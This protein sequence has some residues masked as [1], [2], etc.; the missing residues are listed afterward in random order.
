MKFSAGA[1]IRAIAGL[2]CA[3]LMAAA[4]VSSGTDLADG[5]QPGADENIVLGTDDLPVAVDENGDPIPASIGDP[6]E[7]E[8]EAS[9]QDLVEQDKRDLVAPPADSAKA[10]PDDV[11]A[12]GPRSDPDSL[13]V[14]FEPGTTDEA[15]TS[16]LAGAGVEGERIGDSDAVLV[17]TAGVDKAEVT[18]ALEA[19]GAVAHVEPNLIR[20]A[21]KVPNDPQTTTQRHY[22]DGLGIQPAWDVANTGSNVV[23]AV[24]DTGVD[25]DH[26]DLAPNLVP[27]Y[28]AVNP[29]ASPQ[30]DNGHGTQVA[31]IIGAATNNGVGIAG[32]AWNA[33]IMPVKVLNAQGYGTDSDIVEGIRWA[34][35]HGADVINMSLGGPGMSMAIDEAVEFA[36]GIVGG[37]IV[38]PNDSVLVAA[39]GN[40]ASWA[41][42]YP[43]AAPG[44][45]AVSATDH[46]NDYFWRSNHGAWIDIAAPGI[47]IT[48]TALAPGTTPAIRTGTGTSFSSPIVAG[49]AA[50]VRE[51]HPGWR[52]DRVHWEVLRTATDR[53]PA[54]HDDAYGFG[55]VNAAAALGVAGAGTVSQPSLTGDAGNLPG[56]ARAITVG[57]PATES[58]GYESDEDWFSFSVPSA[59][60][61]NVTVTPPAAQTTAPRARELDPV[62]EVYGPG[63][64]LVAEGDDGYQGE[65]EVISFVAGPGTHRVRVR[66]WLAS[67]GP[68][69]YTVNVQRPGELPVTELAAPLTVNGLTSPV[70]RPVVADVTDDGRADIIVGGVAGGTNGLYLVAM[71]ADG[72]PATPQLLIDNQAR[73]GSTVVAADLDG[74]GD[75]DVAMSTQQG[76]AVVWNTPAGLEPVVRYPNVGVGAIVAVDFDDTA[77][78]EILETPMVGSSAPRLL[79][80]SGSG[81][82]GTFLNLGSSLGLDA[83]AAQHYEAG[84]VNGDGRTDI[85]VAWYNTAGVFLQ[86]PSGTWTAQHF[87]PEPVYGI[88]YRDITIGDVSSDGRLDV[89]LVAEETYPDASH[90]SISRLQQ[91]NGELG[92]PSYLWMASAPGQVSIDDLTGD[93]RAD[94]LVS[95]A[96]ALGVRPQTT[97]GHPA[98]TE[99]LF[100]VQAGMSN[101]F[102]TGQLNADSLAD[103]VVA[104]PTSLLILR[105]QVATNPAPE[106]TRPWV[107]STAPAPHATGGAVTARPALTFGRNIDAESVRYGIYSGD[108]VLL[109]DARGDWWLDATASLNGRTLTVT[110][111]QNLT[112]GTPYRVWIN[113]VRD[114]AGNEIFTSFTFT[115]A[116]AGATTY[117]LGAEYFPFSVDLDANGYDDVVWYTPGTNLDPVWG[118]FPDGRFDIGNFDIRGTFRPVA[119]DFDGNGY[120]D[121]FWYAPGT[122][123]D[124]M[125]YFG[126]PGLDGALTITTKTY[127]INSTYVPVAG[128]FDGN[129]YEDIFW[130]GP[131]TAAESVWK[132]RAG[133]AFTAVNQSK[134]NAT[135]FR[136]TAGD[137]D[138][139]GYDD[140]FWHLPGTGG[141]AIWRGGPS[142]FRGIAAPAANG[143][144][145][146]RAGDYNGDG[147]DDIYWFASNVAT[148]A[149]GTTT[150]FTGR[151]GPVIAGTARPVAGEYTGD[152][153]DDLIAY[154]PGTTADRLLTGRP[155]GLG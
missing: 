65:A 122:A 41:V 129:G 64:G 92:D 7:I 102:A 115:T 143:N 69:A 85:V 13:L 50:M 89:V 51:R 45:I 153:R 22:L 144:Y 88:T 112:P 70:T 99:R 63:N 142:T 127:P 48:S 77:A 24:L 126:P 76:L 117:R 6:P 123:A 113:G 82:T 20:Q 97:T 101:G 37:N 46:A 141:E 26:P 68:A 58:L 128:D 55:V 87:T 43:A 98:L 147:N 57:T 19:N 15:I 133:Q 136:I 29:A 72:T 151:P 52:W 145:N 21:T 10:Q 121:I 135:G 150:G 25:L 106:T 81:F 130:Y 74:D 56:A 138:R 27:G 14:G 84:D 125:W 90:L 78:V 2:T 119:G 104:A 5:P 31:G 12:P 16:A 140:V 36:L 148:L 134:V 154:V 131:G 105:Q 47:D 60:A 110:P 86:Q 11:D 114:T 94:E 83:D 18:T 59:G 4:A 17:R 34:A 9:G 8:V 61:L 54:G 124:V 73:T 44:V 53:G 96:A 38:G 30:D 33:K 139:D 109:T 100:P 107:E 67:A 75:N 62:V 132:F 149:L 120:E 1:R 71:G 111:S 32:V 66:N 39:A 91:A 42:N 49:V 28:N 40:D 93:G 79:R 116:A 95:H 137:F 118:H 108:T 23:V 152:A 103:V 146:I 35:S 155:T 80:W 3:A